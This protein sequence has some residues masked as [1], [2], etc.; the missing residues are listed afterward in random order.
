M[1]EPVF[2][3]TMQVALVVHNLETTMRTYVDEYGI[4]PWEI[5]ASSSIPT[6]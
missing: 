6:P 1:R 2:T 5:E 4:G 3:E